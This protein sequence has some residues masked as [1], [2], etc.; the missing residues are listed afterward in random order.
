MRARKQTKR[1]ATKRTKR[2]PWF[3]LAGLTVYDG[4]DPGGPVALCSM[5]RSIPEAVS[6]FRSLLTDH[7]EVLVVEVERFKTMS[8]TGADID[9]AIGRAR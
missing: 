8:T 5:A 1:R 7:P 4:R 6:L 3:S 2:G 9:A